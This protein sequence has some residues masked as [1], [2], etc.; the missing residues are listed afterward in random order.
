MT[1]FLKTLMGIFVLFALLSSSSFAAVEDV[2]IQAG[3]PHS[4]G[5]RPSWNAEKRSTNAQSY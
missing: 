3:P 4:W 5:N 1:Y 2:E